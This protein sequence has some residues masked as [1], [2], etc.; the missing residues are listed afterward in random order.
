M[1][2]PQVLR[3]KQVSTRDVF[4]RLNFSLYVL[5]GSQDKPSADETGENRTHLL[6]CKELKQQLLCRVDLSQLVEELITLLGLFNDDVGLMSSSRLLCWKSKSIFNFTIWWGRAKVQLKS[7]SLVSQILTDRRATRCV[8]VSGL[9]FVFLLVSV[10]SNTGERGGPGE[11]PDTAVSVSL[12]GDR[13]TGDGQDSLSSGLFGAQCCGTAP[14]ASL[15]LKIIK[16]LL[17]NCWT[18]AHV[19]YQHW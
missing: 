8:C 12:Q 14:S 17:L 2:Q 1:Q 18:C 7:L 13:T 9:H 3:S 6:P 19:H 16:V 11:V 5:F 4:Y 15:E 10:C